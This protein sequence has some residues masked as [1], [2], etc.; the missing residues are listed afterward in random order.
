MYHTHEITRSVRCG[1][2]QKISNSIES[3]VFGI[4]WHRQNSSDQNI[5]GLVTQ[6]LF[7]IQMN[8][9][10]AV[11][12]FCLHSY[13]MSMSLR[14]D[15]AQNTSQKQRECAVP[16]GVIE[17]PLTGHSRDSKELGFILSP[18]GSALLVAVG[19]SSSLGINICHSSILK[20]VAFDVGRGDNDDRRWHLLQWQ[21]QTQCQKSLN[22]GRHVSSTIV[23][24][25]VYLAFAMLDQ[26]VLK[27]CAP[28]SQKSSK[29]SALNKETY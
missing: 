9:L 14:N 26:I 7:Q 19:L 1:L 28:L 23:E 29:H 22:N 24:E 10:K 11:T 8:I 6:C 16:W 4:H 21:S 13:Q 20:D 17:R 18:A 25:Q 15:T 5:A 27:A 2:W 3:T 12:T